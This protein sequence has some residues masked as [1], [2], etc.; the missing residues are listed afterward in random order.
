[1]LVGIH[2]YGPLNESRLDPAHFREYTARE[3]VAAGEQAGLRCT[4]LYLANYFE[5]E[6]LA[7]RVYNT[8]ARV[9]PPRLR[10]GITAIFERP[11]PS[12]TMP[13]S[14]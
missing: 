14:I 6:S 2:P 4:E 13:P 11:V 9:M 8:T 5:R 10:A 3:I 7:S 12:S 1:M